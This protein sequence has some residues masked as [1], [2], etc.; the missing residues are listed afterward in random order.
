MINLQKSRMDPFILMMLGQRN[1]MLLN[2]VSRITT[3]RANN[4]QPGELFSMRYGKCPNFGI[5]HIGSH[6]Q[7][8]RRR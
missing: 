2:E 8:S 7:L 6:S 3:N 5:G 1:P 4:A